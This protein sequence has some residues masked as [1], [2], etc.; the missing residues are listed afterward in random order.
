MVNWLWCIMSLS[1]FSKVQFT[2]QLQISIEGKM[3]ATIELNLPAIDQFSETCNWHA[4]NGK[5]N[6]DCTR[7]CKLQFLAPH[8]CN[9]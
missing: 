8:K 2:Q 6:A 9:Y 5:A 7:P 1:M 4:E 3:P